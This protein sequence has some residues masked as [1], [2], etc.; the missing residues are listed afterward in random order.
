MNHLRSG[1]L[2]AAALV[3]AC[4]EAQPAARPASVSAPMPNAKVMSAASRTDAGFAARDSGAL[5]DDVAAQTVVPDS[6]LD[7]AA[8]TEMVHVPEGTLLLWSTEEYNGTEKST[9]RAFD[10][11]RT[12]VTLAQ[13]EACV[14]ARACPEPRP[15]RASG[16]SKQCNWGRPERDH[17]PVNC[18]TWGQAKTYC[19]WVQKRLPS[20]AEWDFAARG[21]DGRKA[22]WGTLAKVP[23]GLMCG[24]RRTTEERQQGDGTC[25][26][27][28][29]PGDV[30]PYGVLDMGGNVG[31]FTADPYVYRNSDERDEIRG[32]VTRGGDWREGD[33]SARSCALIRSFSECESEKGDVSWYDSMGFRCAR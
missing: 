32:H 23:H 2:T 12:E 25:E 13:F 11:D 28:S 22:P 8:P 29:H 19:E 16:W 24:E 26:V 27:G 10:I 5:F 30:S 15:N 6:G 1:S 20:E 18:V 7:V 4:V 33:S 14:R 3:V 21:T 31:E 17:H 9:V